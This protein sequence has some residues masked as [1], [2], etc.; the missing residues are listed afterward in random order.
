MP[1]V[2]E[3][4]KILSRKCLFLQES[5]LLKFIFF[6][7]FKTL[8]IALIGFLCVQNKRVQ[9]VTGCWNYTRGLLEM[10][11]GCPHFPAES[12]SWLS[13]VFQKSRLPPILLWCV[14]CTRSVGSSPSRMAGTQKS[15]TQKR[16]ITKSSA[17]PRAPL[18]TVK[19]PIGK[20][21]VKKKKNNKT[22]LILFYFY[23]TPDFEKQVDAWNN[24]KPYLS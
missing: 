18:Q 4:L 8:W 1:A 11:A 20:C 12:M 9:S 5:K 22:T 7:F 15:S 3:D 6:F 13:F 17:A 14:G 2:T 24:C 23:Q 19:N 16:P 21:F 10:K